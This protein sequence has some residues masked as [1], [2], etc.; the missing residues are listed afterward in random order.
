VAFGLAEQLHYNSTM[1]Q[2][3]LPRLLATLVAAAAPLA[4][5]TLTVSETTLPQS[6]ACLDGQGP[7]R[8]AAFTLPADVDGAVFI[9]G[10]GSGPT[11]R[12]NQ[13]IG[14]PCK[15]ATDNAACESQV[16]AL[17][18]D[19]TISGWTF[20]RGYDFSS[21]FAVVTRGSRVQRITKLEE[22]RALVA[23][24]DSLPKAMAMARFS[25]YYITC[26]PG[27]ARTDADGYVLKSVSGGCSSPVVETLYKVFR[28]GRVVEIA[29]TTLR[30]GES[31]C[32]E[33]RRPAGMP[34]TCSDSWL[35]ST[36]EHLREVES[37]ETAAIWAFEDLHAQLMQVGAPADLLR[38]IASARQDEIKHARIMQRILRKRG[39]AA[40]AVARPARVAQS[41]LELATHNATEGCVRETYGALVATHQ[42]TYAG[43]RELRA[44][45][46]TIAAEE[47]THAQLSIDLAAWFNTQLSA[48]ERDQVA[49]EKA[50]AI[51]Q[52]MQECASLNP[53]LEVMRDTGMPGAGAAML[54][55]AGL[56][57]GLDG[58]QLELAA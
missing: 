58:Q 5:C 35:Q 37:M 51:A 7:D 44:A 2:S 57:E 43:N 32:V 22:L 19:K 27:N 12:A 42:A 39:I 34:N 54:M 14:T 41:L 24:I 6:V 25:D 55:L 29:S 28:D 31:G 48:H 50:E 56:L 30:A 36:A 21:D 49:S 47:T 53:A 15:T 9:A 40:K 1:S 38:R 23:P 45:F 11:S 18:A 46:R 10:A 8:Y 26:T 33:G 13:T 52:L 3:H 16:A 20:D 4:A 17:S